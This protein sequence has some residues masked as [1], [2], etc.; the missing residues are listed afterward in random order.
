MSDWLR[1]HADKAALHS[2]TV[3]KQSNALQTA[4][5]SLTLPAA[6]HLT[7]LRELHLDK[8]QVTTAGAS[9]LSSRQH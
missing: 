1:A 2:I 7:A 3:V 5:L 8:M 6:Q 4:P 9:S